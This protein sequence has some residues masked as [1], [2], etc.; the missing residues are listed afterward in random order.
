MAKTLLN[1]VNEVLKKTDILDSD[2]GVLTSLTDSGK[3]VFIDTAVQVIN[4]ALDELYSTAQISKPKQLR[5]ATITLVSGTKD[6]ALHSSL[7]ML[8]PE[9]GLIDQTN[10]HIIGIL[11]EDGYWQTVLGDIDQDDTGLP[12][13]CAISPITERLVFD[14][15]PTSTD[16]GRVYKYR[17]DR[18]MEL[19]SATDTFPFKNI[20]FRALMPA[21]TE[22]WRREHQQEFSQKMFDRSMAR[23]A[24]YLRQT[25][26]RSSYT[27]RQFEA[28]ETDPFNAA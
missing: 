20:V 24:R 5:E 9:Y 11:G 7:Q 19:D 21:A 13:Y 15:T 16:A 23:A 22:L 1:G 18:D 12:S 27:P 25:P 4:E 6:Y 10:N 2:A 14:R 26:P 28:N 17:Y 3:Q 8:R